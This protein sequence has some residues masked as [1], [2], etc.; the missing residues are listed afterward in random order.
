MERTYP[1]IEA[2]GHAV[3]SL[4]DLLS[5][6]Q[7]EH[8]A[9]VDELKAASLALREAAYQLHTGAKKIRQEAPQGA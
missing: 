6:I 8:V 9:P 5:Q 2:L 3:D 1:S 4:A 7:R